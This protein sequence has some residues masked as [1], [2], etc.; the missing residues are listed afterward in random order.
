MFKFRRWKSRQDI[1]IQ[2]VNNNTP[3]FTFY[4]NNKRTQKTD[5]TMYLFL[6]ILIT[7]I[8]LTIDEPLAYK[9]VI[10]L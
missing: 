7:T 1:Y 6:L 5:T 8:C 9:K 2:S 3:R 4:L 10:I